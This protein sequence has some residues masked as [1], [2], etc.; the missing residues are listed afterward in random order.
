MHHP[1]SAIPPARA[2]TGRPPLLGAL[3][4]ALALAV[5]APA[6]Q[7]ARPRTVRSSHVAGVVSVTAG[8]TP[9]IAYVAYVPQSTKAVDHVDVT[10]NPRTGATAGPVHIRFSIAA[11]RA[12]GGVGGGGQLTVPVYGL[13]AGLRNQVK[14]VTSFADGSSE[15][16]PVGV[17]AAAYTDPNKTYDRPNVLQARDATRALGY[18]FIY[19]KSGLGTA[20]VIDVDGQIR[21]V[22]TGIPSAFSSA[23]MPDN[24]FII[25]A[26][27]SADISTQDLDGTVVKSGVLSSTVLSFSHNIDFGRDAF[28]TD[29]DDRINGKKNIESTITEMTPTGNVLRVWDFAKIFTD[30]MAARGDDPT[31][32]VLPGLNWMHINS[33]FYDPRDNSLTVSSREQFVVNLDY[34]TAEIR[35]ILGDP[36]KQWHTFASLRARAI[37]LPD[38]DFYPIGQHSISLADDGKLMLF[39][40]GTRSD[41]VAS[42]AP[43]GAGRTFTVVSKYTIDPVTMTGKEIWRYDHA[44][45]V[46]TDY[47][48]SARDGGAGTTLVDYAALGKLGN[49]M[50]LLGLDANAQTV[51]E[52]EY[53]NV[54][55]G[56]GWHARPFPFDNL[57]YP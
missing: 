26:Q 50:R 40:N 56:T 53:P 25:G 15:S 44:P 46:K 10:I 31:Q 9:F 43:R 54:S 29:T 52:Y 11:L 16:L 34:D 24:R 49:R 21:W 41:V 23:F 20:V 12:R 48:G 6:S 38:G 4:C 5:A 30:W 28:L 8:V 42:G 2:A 14:L 22:A 17:K 1:V 27:R 19:I 13:Y 35:W 37:T 55:C 57:V 7:A 32:F 39:N 18:D 45:E 47:C 51:F 33:S 36:G 3:A